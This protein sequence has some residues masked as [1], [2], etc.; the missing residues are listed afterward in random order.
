MRLL[1]ILSRI[2]RRPA[3]PQP[4]GLI[5][6]LLD[7]SAPTADR[8]DAAMDLADFDSPEA[9][10]ALVVVASDSE[11]DELLLDTAGQ[12][13][14]EMWLRWNKKPD[15]DVIRA[16]PDPSRFICVA[17]LIAGRPEWRE[18]LIEALGSRLPERLRP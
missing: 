14:S 18:W 10:A 16:F 15:A 12:S 17:G 6:V 3:V 1:E 2:M 9:E 8:D 11:E 4:A 5:G 7:K 13:L